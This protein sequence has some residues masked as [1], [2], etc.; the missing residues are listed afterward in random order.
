MQESV[1]TML[2]KSQPPAGDMEADIDIRSDEDPAL[3]AIATMD[4][5]TLFPLPFLFPFL[6]LFF[7][8]ALL[9]LLIYPLFR[10]PYILECIPP[11]HFKKYNENKH[12]C[13]NLDKI[14]LKWKIEAKN[15]DSR[16]SIKFA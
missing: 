7:S 13:E 5:C 14:R 9:L 12:Y 1:P 6:L 11:R 16:I 10:W 15:M 8:L 2:R 3:E 4:P